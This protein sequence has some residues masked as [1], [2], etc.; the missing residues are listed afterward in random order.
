MIKY[1]IGFEAPFGFKT[2]KVENIEKVGTNHISLKWSIDLDVLRTVN[3]QLNF[4]QKNYYHT[5]TSNIGDRISEQDQAILKNVYFELYLISQQPNKPSL[6]S[7]TLQLRR[8]IKPFRTISAIDL[9]SQSKLKRSFN[10]ESKEADREFVTFEY[11]LTMLRA[12]SLYI[13][14]MSTR[15]YN[16]ESYLTEPL[17]FLT[18]REYLI[19]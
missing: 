14:E 13:M 8:L 9:L 3:K 7:K 1:F 17:K 19:F 5:D 10:D 18:L 12:D 16:L 4:Q 6:S 11:N 15:L 2:I